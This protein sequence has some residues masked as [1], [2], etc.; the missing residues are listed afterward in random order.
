M[1]LFIY[2]FL[3][4]ELV[5]HYLL[6]YTSIEYLSFALLL[7]CGLVTKWI[8]FLI[9]FFSISFLI[10][11]IIFGFSSNPLLDSTSVAIETILLFIY[12]ILFFYDHSKNNRTDYIYN[13]PIF[14]ISVGVLIYLGGSFF[15]NILVNYMS[16]HEFDAYWRYTYFAEILKNLF[17]G[18]AILKTPNHIKINTLKPSQVPYLD[19]D[20]N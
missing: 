15:F 17:F 14:W 3:P 7:Y 8:K 9:V 1:W 16:K 5:K 11:Q 2:D 10:F 18:L 6:V 19:M 4:N 12:I 20:M 13:H